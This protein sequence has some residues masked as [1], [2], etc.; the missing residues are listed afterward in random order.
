MKGGFS[1]MGTYMDRVKYRFSSKRFH[2][3]I[4]SLSEDQK[5]F[6]EK[7]GLERFLGFQKFN[8]PMPFLEWV[9]G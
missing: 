5:G 2:K 3:V 4:H 8:V 9:I 6:L 1:R 7:Y